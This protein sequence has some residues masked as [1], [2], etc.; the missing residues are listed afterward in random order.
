MVQEGI[1][2]CAEADVSKVWSPAI[3]LRGR[4]RGG[5]WNPETLRA[6]QKEC[7]PHRGTQPA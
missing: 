3:G 4:R 7:D 6:V 1:M 5:S 2:Q